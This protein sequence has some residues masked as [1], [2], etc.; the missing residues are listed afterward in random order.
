MDPKEYLKQAAKTEQKIK[1]D[2]EKLE[3]AKASL[4]GR[5]ITYDPDGSKTASRKNGMEDAMIRVLDYEEHIN[6]EISALTELRSKIEKEIFAVSDET[7]R[8]L[9]TR[10]YLLYQKWEFIAE[11]MNYGVRHIYKLHIKALKAFSEANAGLLCPEAGRY[12]VLGIETVGAIGIRHGNF[13]MKKN[14]RKTIEN[15]AEML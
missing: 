13:Q 1:F 15:P 9:L 7:L 11:E 12:A 8:E 5:A 4:H 10:R 3:A 2:L 14:F 6:A